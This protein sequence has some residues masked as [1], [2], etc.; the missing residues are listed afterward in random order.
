MKGEESKLEYIANKVNRVGH[1]T[2]SVNFKDDVLHNNTR[3]TIFLKKYYLFFTFANKKLF[4][5]SHLLLSSGSL[6]KKS[7]LLIHIF[8][9]KHNWQIIEL[10]FLRGYW[11]FDSEIDITTFKL[12]DIFTEM[13]LFPYFSCLNSLVWF[14]Y[15]SVC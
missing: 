12:S 9:A 8:S 1:D 15:F 7:S 2:I 10:R 3:Q 11:V 13:V 4:K 5:C 6:F 14:M